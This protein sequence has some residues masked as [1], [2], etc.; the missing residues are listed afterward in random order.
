MDD[1][2]RHHLWIALLGRQDHPTDGVEDYCTF[3]GQALKRRGIILERVRLAWDEQGWIS[4]L[5]LFRSDCVS[6]RGRWVLFQYTAL[7][8]SQRGFPVR[9]LLV[10]GI[11]RRV[12]ARV[13]VVFHEPARQTQSARRWIDH[14]RGACQDWVIHRLYKGA[15][16]CIF[17]DPL[18]TIDWLPDVDRKSA[19]I[20]IGANIPAIPLQQSRTEQTDATKSVAIFGVTD[21]GEQR[22]RWELSE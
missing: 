16:K 1:L 17:A 8:W 14:F 18:N 20:P 10:L 2:S 7:S 12:G 3:L 19:F 5:R 15:S 11:L 21:S 22:Q 13:A 6:W 4:A 9:A